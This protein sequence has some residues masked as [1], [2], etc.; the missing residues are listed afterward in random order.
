MSYLI[1]HL[2]NIKKMSYDNGF[3]LTELLI[4][5]VVASISI[6]GIF[7]LTTVMEKNYKASIKVS[8]MYDQSRIAMERMFKEISET[9]ND[10][11]TIQS[12]AI[13]FASARDVNGNFIYKDYTW[14]LKSIRP[15]WQKAIVY[16]LHGDSNK[17]KLYRKEITKTNW[18]TNFN[19]N[20]VIDANGEVIAES[21]SSI[22]FSIYPAD[23]IQ[24]AHSL[25]VNLVLSK[26]KDELGIGIPSSVNL[27]T[28][29]PIM[30]R[31]R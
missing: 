7:S 10:T 3:S 27:N 24:K 2:T 23:T 9:S 14:V 28:R 18:S 22:T 19:P 13:S 17:K 11:I 20:G 12:N 15:S 5:T 31:K 8:N 21:V 4:A 6:V 16:Y 25:Q 26:S 29:I 1:K 30:N